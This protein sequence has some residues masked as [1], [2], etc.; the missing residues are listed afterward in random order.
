VVADAGDAELF[1]HQGEVDYLLAGQ[2][3]LR[4]DAA[5][6]R[7]S[8]PLPGLGSSAAEVRELVYAAPLLVVVDGASGRVIGLDGDGLAVRLERRIYTT[9]A[10]PVTRL[11]AVQ[12]RADQLTIVVAERDAAATGDTQLLAMT[13]PLA[14]RGKSEY[15]TRI[16]LGGGPPKSDHELSPIAASDGGGALLLRTHAGNTGPLVALTQL[17]L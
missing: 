12:S 3:V 5:G 17:H 16:L 1:L 11:R 4:L 9:S 8:Q 7:T 2:R 13:L 6:S 15:P 14:A 10:H